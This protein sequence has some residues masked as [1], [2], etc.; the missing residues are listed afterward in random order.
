MFAATLA[1]NTQRTGEFNFGGRRF[2][3]R[4]VLFPTPS[5]AEWFIVD[6]L[7]HRELAGVALT[8]LLQ[9]LTSTLR[10]GRWDRA[11][12]REMASKYCT[13][14]TGA[15]VQGCLEGSVL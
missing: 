9:R 7:Q 13:K 15:L 10:E 1:Y 2:L 4:R 3:L 6:L 8:R 14:A 11:L 12:L 5:Q